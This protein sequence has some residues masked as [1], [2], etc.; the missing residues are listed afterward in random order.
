MDKIDGKLLMVC[1]KSNV[2]GLVSIGDIQR[3]I[4]K[5]ADLNRKVIDILGRKTQIGNSSESYEHI[6][7]KMIRYRME[8]YPIIDRQNR[9]VDCYFWE[10]LH[11]TLPEQVGPL[12]TSVVIL[13]VD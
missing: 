2:I 5:T 13:A 1:D 8:Y 9:L 4:I 7:K 3:E 11:S 6:K 12:N 10:D